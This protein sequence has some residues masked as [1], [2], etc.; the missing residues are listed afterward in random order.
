MMHACRLAGLSGGAVVSHID[1]TNRKLMELRASGRRNGQRRQGALPDKD[2]RDT[3][4]G[5]AA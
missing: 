3:V 1:I 5:G 4:A 2:T